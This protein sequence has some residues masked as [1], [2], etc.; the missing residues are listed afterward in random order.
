MEVDAGRTNTVESGPSVGGAVADA[1]GVLDD[2][3]LE[4]EEASYI[5]TAP[6]EKIAARRLR[7]QKRL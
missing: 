1:R 3:L 5:K 4:K 6:R 2:L 7:R